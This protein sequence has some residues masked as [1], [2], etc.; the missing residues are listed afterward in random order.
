MAVTL[1]EWLYIVVNG[2]KWLYMSLSAVYG[3]EWMEMAEDVQEMV[4]NG[5]YGWI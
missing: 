3:Y 1:L 2:C 4:R 5:W